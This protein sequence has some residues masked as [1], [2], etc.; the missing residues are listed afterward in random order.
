VLLALRGDLALTSWPGEISS[1]DFETRRPHLLVASAGNFFGESSGRLGITGRKGTHVESV[2]ETADM[3]H[4]AMRGDQVARGENFGVSGMP[5]AG[6]DLFQT[7][8]TERESATL[9]LGIRG[10]LSSLTSGRVLS[11]L[12][13]AEPRDVSAPLL[14]SSPIPLRNDS[15]RCLRFSKFV[16]CKDCNVLIATSLAASSFSSSDGDTMAMSG[17]RSASSVLETACRRSSLAFR[18]SSHL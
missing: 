9:S 8:A 14:S 4:R 15:K 10:F 13:V 1:G 2:S 17:D 7:A 12:S 16:L 18:R 11:S 6:R 5:D 3:W